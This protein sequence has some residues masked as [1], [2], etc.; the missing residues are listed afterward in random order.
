MRNLIVRYS[1]LPSHGLGGRVS[2]CNH[3]RYPQQSQE[4]S[5]KVELQLQPSEHVFLRKWEK[6][7]SLQNSWKP[8]D[9][10]SNAFNKLKVRSPDRWTATRANYGG[11]TTKASWQNAKFTTTV[12]L[13]AL[14]RS[15]KL[16]SHEAL[17]DLIPRSSRSPAPCHWKSQKWESSEVFI[18]VE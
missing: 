1:A 9:I 14:R 2:N 15:H 5:P 17:S 12:P 4:E 16:C 18:C 7:R 8:R 10:S 3:T 6:Q 13:T 11:H